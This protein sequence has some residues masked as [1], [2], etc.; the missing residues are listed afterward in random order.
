M[1]MIGPALAGS[2]LSSLFVAVSPQLFSPAILLAP[3]WPLT[4]APTRE[5]P[6]GREGNR[7]EHALGWGTGGGRETETEKR[8]GTS[9]FSKLSVPLQSRLRG[10]GHGGWLRQRKREWKCFFLFYFHVLTNGADVFD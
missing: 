7:H 3:G 4:A 6:N 9:V 2:T 1:E 8:R 5:I 10:I